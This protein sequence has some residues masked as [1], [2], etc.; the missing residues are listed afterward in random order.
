MNDLTCPLCRQPH[1]YIFEI[2]IRITP[3]YALRLGQTHDRCR[4]FFMSQPPGKHPVRAH[5]GICGNTL[6]IEV[7]V[8]GQKSPV[9]VRHRQLLVESHQP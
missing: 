7:K 5:R 6:R 4:K 1:Q 9:I 3:I 8:N 2:G